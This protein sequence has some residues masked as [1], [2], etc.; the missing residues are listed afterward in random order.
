MKPS[1]L[2]L[3]RRET[4]LSLLAIASTS[5]VA[6]KDNAGDI[7]KNVGGFKL[8]DPFLNGSEMALLTAIAGLIIP[9][10][11]T[12]GAV[13][14]GVQDTIQELLSNW[15][16]DDVRSYWRGGLKAVSGK[17][18]DVDDFVELPVEKQMELLGAL[19]KGVYKDEID[20]PFYKDL[21]RAVVGAY[22]MS[23]A[24]ATQ[25][26]AYDPVPG[27]FKGCIDFDEIGKAWAT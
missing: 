16:E 9:N 18:G 5:L 12:P 4:M 14:A 24:G 19:D 13:E 7:K 8:G 15:G 10:T 6:C 17:F 1:K 23:E 22:Y 2:N 20:L 11:D 27:D 21:K 3:T 26:L 25:E